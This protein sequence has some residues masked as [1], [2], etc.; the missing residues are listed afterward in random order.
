MKKAFSIVVG[1]VFLLGWL[2]LAGAM[3]GCSQ[4]EGL[5]KVWWNGAELKP[6]QIG[7]LTVLADTSLYKVDG[8]EK[9]YTRKLKAGEFYRI[10]AFKPG[11]LSVGGGYYVERDSR[12]NY[13]TPSKAK[14]EAAACVYAS[15]P[16][17]QFTNLGPTI[18]NITAMTAATGYGPDGTPLMYV[19]MQGQPAKLVV[20]DI[21]RN[22]MVDQK[23][24]GTSTSAWAITV[25]AG[26]NA[27]IGGT[28][29]EHLYRYNPGTKTLTD[30]GKATVKG[31][32]IHDLEALPNG[33]IYGSGSP[34]GNVFRYKAG[35]GFTDLGQVL[36]DK[37][38]ARSLAYNE[39]T[40]T[41]FVGVGAKAQLAAWN[42]ATNKKQAILPAAYQGETSVYDLDEENGF[43]FAKLE[44]SKKILVFNSSTYAFLGELPASSRGVSPVVEKE[45]A[46]YFTHQYTLKKYDLN[47]RKVTSIPGTTK[48]TE[49]VAMDVIDLH[50]NAYPGES[51][52]SLLGN[53]GTYMIYNPAT[54]QSKISKFNL[55]PQPIPIYS[56]AKGPD[57]RIYTN[58]FVS[59]QLS[60]YNPGDGS[61]KSLLKVGQAESMAPLNGKLYLGV[62]PG[63][64]LY[65][66]NPATDTLG[67]PSPLFSVGNGQD[68]IAAMA[69]DPAT[70]T[71]FM[72]TH[73]KNGEVGGAFVA[74]NTKTKTKTIRRNIVQNQSVVSLA[75][76][77]GYVYGG[78][79]IFSNSPSEGTYTAKFFRLK[80]GQPGSQPEFISLPLTK[81]RMIHALAVAPN[82]VIW[83]LSDGNLFAYDPR[84]KTTKIISITANTSGRFKNGSLVIGKDGNVY[85]TVEQ[86]LFKVFP[87]TM[88]KKILLE[89]GAANLAMDNNG[90]LF[91]NNNTEL[92]MYKTN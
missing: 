51:V 24:L 55:P 80:T 82:G 9:V 26:Q 56:I 30:V 62:Y 28:P 63:A 33:T 85:G 13:E 22:K 73:P 38:L 90:A 44:P 10:Y 40:N 65:E 50:S 91:F 57:G 32:S 20:M 27:W 86:K 37:K 43:L 66:Y 54:G 11:M 74:Y 19:V 14:L 7:R 31:T 61:I 75:V 39:K 2:P 87:A 79:S 23:S 46:V 3:G 53:T 59:G 12:V 41:L 47:T 77:G 81:P 16:V 92:W 52:V 29:S 64:S 76:S 48:G 49:A 70:N 72:G 35:Q 42:L 4:Y 6:G 21:L 84:T 5:D 8:E 78:T 83:G 67:V 15:M 34:N 1:L 88:T 60:A 45:N 71:I 89:K 58:G 69:V 68:R 36:P 18:E 25:D 17:G